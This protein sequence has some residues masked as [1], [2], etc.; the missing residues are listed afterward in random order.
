MILLNQ[1]VSKRLRRHV[2]AQDYVIAELGMVPP[3]L[4]ISHHAPSSHAKDDEYQDS[5]DRLLADIESLHPP[6]SNTNIRLIWCCDLNTQ[7]NAHPPDIG[8]WTNGG[9]REGESG[10]AA[11]V[12]G[13]IQT[14][15]LKIFST[16]VDLGFTRFAWPGARK[17]ENSNSIIDFIIATPS[18]KGTVEIADTFPTH[19]SSDHKP[20]HFR[21]L[22]PKRDKRQRRRLMEKYLRMNNQYPR[23][24][25][26][27]TP[28]DPNHFK[29][30]FHHIKATN[31]Q[32]F[33]QQA[34]TI[35]RKHTS[36]T[37]FENPERARVAERTQDG[38]RSGSA[39][40]L[41]NLSSAADPDPESAERRG[42]T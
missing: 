31:L 40:C 5:F 39:A 41:P 27:W 1:R 13:A 9:E 10:R 25:A 32:D 21:T 18:L 14:L 34:Q 17:G 37:P 19:V 6:H 35:A 8:P 29:H 22:A 26:N 15:S 3:V 7:V 12:S 11:T 38:P 42:T 4:I 2:I 20:L 36:H 16:F 24:P 33:S 23:L 28:Q 30:D